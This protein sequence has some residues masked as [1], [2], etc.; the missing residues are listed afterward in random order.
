MTHEFE[1]L[2]LRYSEGSPA[3]EFGQGFATLLMLRD[4]GE[5]GDG[6]D[7]GHSGGADSVPPAPIVWNGLNFLVG[8]GLRIIGLGGIHLLSI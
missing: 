8:L 6:P 2:K 3:L 7:Q 4:A 1:R 5:V